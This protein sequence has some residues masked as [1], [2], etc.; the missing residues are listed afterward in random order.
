MAQVY[1]TPVCAEFVAYFHSCY[2]RIPRLN[3]GE[4]PKIPNEGLG[5]NPGLSP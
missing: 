3:R 1:S 4:A 2:K 5:L